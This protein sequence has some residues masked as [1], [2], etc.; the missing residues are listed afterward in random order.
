MHIVAVFAFLFGAMIGLTMAVDHFRG[1]ESGKLIGLAHGTFTISGIVL[2]TV[3]MLYSDIDAWLA[4]YAFLGTAVGGLFLFYR[5]MT[6]K[7]WPSAVILIH[8]GA[9]IAS[10][11]LLIGLLVNAGNG[12]SRDAEPGVPAVTSGADG[13]GN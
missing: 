13:G 3:G 4:L 10:I 11:V 9:A 6:G 7:K 8:G 12:A 1:K 5:Q 2:L